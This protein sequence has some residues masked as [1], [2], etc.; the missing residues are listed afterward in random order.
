V[1]EFSSISFRGYKQR[2]FSSSW[3]CVPIVA[4]LSFHLNEQSRM[5]LND[6]VFVQLKKKRSFLSNLNFPYSQCV[7]WEYCKIHPV[8]TFT[9]KKSLLPTSIIFSQTYIRHFIN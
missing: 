9:E 6:P 2:S 4:I 5:N 1:K 8:S 7:L 3:R